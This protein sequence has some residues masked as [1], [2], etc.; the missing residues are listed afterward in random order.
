[1]A[2]AKYILFCLNESMRTS[3][4]SIILALAT[5]RRSS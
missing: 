1:M 5:Q 3:L 4:K 2:L